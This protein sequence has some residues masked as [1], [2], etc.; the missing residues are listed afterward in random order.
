ML[1]LSVRQKNKLRIQLYSTGI[2]FYSLDSCCLI[3]LILEKVVLAN[4]QK[5]CDL[6]RDFAA[7]LVYS[8][9]LGSAKWDAIES[10]I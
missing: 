4:L 6:H 5:G 3:V 8:L 7:S 10:L 2:T 9:Q 1:E